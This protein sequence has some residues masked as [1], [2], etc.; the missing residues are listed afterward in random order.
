MLLMSGALWPDLRSKPNDVYSGFH[1]KQAKNDLE[2]ART[3]NKL[4]TGHSTKLSPTA[5]GA[6][7]YPAMPSS[8][9]VEMDRSTNGQLIDADQRALQIELELSMLGLTNDDDQTS[10]AFDEIRNK[11]SVNMTECVPVPSSEH[12]AEIVGRQ[13]KFWTPEEAKIELASW[14]VETACIWRVFVPRLIWRL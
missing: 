7:T 6:R 13:G 11:R 14:L 9:L 8:L 4:R 12:V 3:S 2:V 1:L 10:N 5:H